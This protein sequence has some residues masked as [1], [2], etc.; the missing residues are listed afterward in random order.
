MKL[1][2]N[3]LVCTDFSKAAELALDAAAIV[4][5]QNHAKVTLAHVVDGHALN[6]LPTGY[7]DSSSHSVVAESEIEARIHEELKRLRDARFG[8]VEQAKTVVIVDEDAAH[9]IVEYA[10]KEDVDLIVLSTH[11]RTGL[12]HVLIGSVAEKVVSTAPCPV[13]TLRSRTRE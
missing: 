3:I 5:M 12:E 11:G 6:A 2:Q 13:L 4:A 9:G 7:F 1:T 8:E 10:K